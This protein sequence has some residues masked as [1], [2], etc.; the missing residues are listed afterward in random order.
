MNYSGSIRPV[1]AAI[2]VGVAG[3]S[4]A[5]ALQG[6]DQSFVHEQ[7]FSYYYNWEEGMPA[8]PGY[9]SVFYENI[10]TYGWY[11][12]TGDT[13]DNNPYGM[14]FDRDLYRVNRILT[15][16]PGQGGTFTPRSA[17]HYGRIAP[18][19][20]FNSNLGVGTFSDSGVRR[21]STLSPFRGSGNQITGL[22]LIHAASGSLVSTD[23]NRNLFSAFDVNYPDHLVLGVK[24]SNFRLRLDGA[25]QQ[26]YEAHALESFPVY[27]NLTLSFD[28]LMGLEP[29]IRYSF[30]PR[31]YLFDFNLLQI[32]Y[33]YILEDRFAFDLNLPPYNLTPDSK[34]YL[35]YAVFMGGFDGHTEDFAMDR[36]GYIGHYRTEEHFSQTYFEGEELLRLGSLFDLEFD[37]GIS[38]IRAPQPPVLGL[39]Y[40]VNSTTTGFGMWNGTVW[41]RTG[42]SFWTA[43][44]LGDEQ[45][46]EWD[47]SG[48]GVET[49]IFDLAGQPGVP[50]VF[51]AETIPMASSKLFIEGLG[52]E[53]DGKAVL[54]FY[55]QPV[56][57]ENGFIDIE[58]EEQA[59]RAD[60]WISGSFTLQGNGTLIAGNG[61]LLG[62]AV[63][64]ENG[65]LFLDHEESVDSQTSIAL[66]PDNLSHT[67]PTLTLNRSVSLHELSAGNFTVIRPSESSNATLTLTGN[68]TIR[69]DLT[70]AWDTATNLPRVMSVTIDAPDSTVTFYSPGKVHTG[71]TTLVAGTLNTVGTDALSSDS[72]MVVHGGLLYINGLQ[73][74]LGLS[75]TG[76]EIRGLEDS[77]RGL[78]IAL[79]KIIRP[80]YSNSDRV[81]I[82]SGTF[83][84]DLHVEVWYVDFRVGGNN[85]HTGW[86]STPNSTDSFSV[87][88]DSKLTLGLGGDSGD[89]GFGM[90]H[91]FSGDLVVDR[92][93][94]YLMPNIIYGSGNLTKDGTG[95]LILTGENTYSGT[96]VV[97]SGRLF[98]NSAS[99][100]GGS[101]LVKSGATVGGNGSKSGEMILES[102]AR[103]APGASVGELSTGNQT[104]NG[105]SI[106]EFE[107]TTDGSSGSAGASWDK[108]TVNG[109]LDMT[110]ASNISPVVIEL[111]TMRDIISRGVLNSWNPTA[112]AKWTDFVTTTDGILGYDVDKFSFD[113]DAFA[114]PLAPNG[115]FWVSL[116]GG[117]NNLDLNYSLPGLIFD[118]N[119]MS[120]GYGNWAS[121]IP[122]MWDV[123]TTR[124]F[125]RSATGSN[126]TNTWQYGGGGVETTIFDVTGQTGAAR[127]QVVG[128]IEMGASTLLVNGTSTQ[129]LTLQGGLLNFSNGTI[130]VREPSQ[131]LRIAGNASIS[132][133]ATKSGPGKLEVA[134]NLLNS[135]LSVDDG[136]LRLMTS[137]NTGNNTRL[138]L[139]S[140]NAKLELAGNGTFRLGA[141]NTTSGSLARAI[142]G[143]V[144]ELQLVLMNGETNFLY[145]RLFD[146]SA[147]LSLT[148]TGAGAALL[149]T[150][151]AATYSGQTLVNGAT[152]V[153]AAY[154]S[155]SPNSVHNL[156]S[157]GLLSITAD[158]V[159]AGLMGNGRVA[160]NGQLTIR[161]LLDLEFSGTIED[162]DSGVMSLMK[163]YSGLL[164]LS[165]NNTFTGTTLIEAGELRIGAGGTTGTLLGNGLVSNNA[166][167]SFNRSDE[168]LFGSLISGSGRIVQLGNGTTTLTGNNTFQ[169]PSIIRN[170]TLQLGNGGISGAIGLGPVENEAILSFNRSD[171]VILPNSIGGNGSVEQRGTGT[172]TL[173]FNNTYSGG[174]WIRNGALRIG[175]NGTTGWFGSGQVRDDSLLVFNR[176]DNITVE[177][178]IYG[179]GNLTQI[180]PGRLTLTANNTYS[181]FTRL[182]NG[183]FALSAGS[184]HTG[185]STYF[186]DNG[187]RFLPSEHSL[188]TNSAG[189]G[190]AL[191][192]LSG[193]IFSFS[194]NWNTSGRSVKV[195]NLG[196]LSPG[197]FIE[198]TRWQNVEEP[199]FNLGGGRFDVSEAQRRVRT[200][201]LGRFVA[202]GDLKFD[203]YDELGGEKPVQGIGERGDRVTLI[204]G[205]FDIGP[206]LS[207]AQ[208]NFNFARPVAEL[209]AG[210]YII[211]DGDMPV[212]GALALNSANHPTYYVHDTYLV[213]LSLEDANPAGGFNDVAVNLVRPV[214]YQLI[215]ED[216]QDHPQT[217]LADTQ[218]Q[219]TF[220]PNSP[221]KVSDRAFESVYFG[222]INS[223]A[224]VSAYGV[225][226]DAEGGGSLWYGRATGTADYPL[227]LLSRQNATDSNVLPDSPGTDLVP[228]QTLDI[229]N[230]DGSVRIATSEI[231]NYRASGYS[232]HP[233]GYLTMITDPKDGAFF[234]GMPMTTEAGNVIGLYKRTWLNVASGAGW[235]AS[236]GDP[237]LSEYSY[238]GVSTPLLVNDAG[239][240]LQLG[241]LTSGNHTQ[242]AW[243][244][245]GEMVGREASF[246]R[247]AP[248]GQRVGDFSAG[249]NYAPGLALSDDG[250]LTFRASGVFEGPG[251]SANFTS[252]VNRQ[253]LFRASGPDGA[254]V[255][256]VELVLRG[257]A[258]GLTDSVA[259]TNRFSYTANYVNGTE[260]ATTQLSVSEIAQTVSVNADGQTATVVRSFVSPDDLGNLSTVDAVVFINGTHGTN[261]NDPGD[262]YTTVI[263]RDGDAVYRG[264]VFAGVTQDIRFGMDQVAATTNGSVGRVYY[265]AGISSGGSSIFYWDEGDRVANALFLPGETLSVSLRHPELPRINLTLG[266][267][268]LNNSRNLGAWQVNARGDVAAETWGSWVPENNVTAQAR[269]FHGVL[270]WDWNGSNYNLS[271]IV[272]EGDTVDN[273]DGTYATLDWM[274]LPGDWVVSNGLDGRPTWFNDNGKITFYGQLHYF[275][276]DPSGAEGY[277]IV[278]EEGVFAPFDLP[279]FGRPIPEPKAITLL[280]LSILA[281]LFH[282]KNHKWLLSHKR[283]F[284]Q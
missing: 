148:T 210:K 221:S 67:W 79:L 85:T 100:G 75:G 167:L 56:N 1:N 277:T 60:N 216:D 184:S 132:G 110:A 71:N 162:A 43:S 39:R 8:T 86:S 40:D 6:Y 160:G 187:S 171:N 244:V 30:D 55:G 15:W 231:Q 93:N 198:G 237:L 235:G 44:N 181:G 89:A 38:L 229:L 224:F 20:S 36:G 259:Q 137:G 2:A 203:L 133:S 47:T 124:N 99:T 182:M 49:T 41:D 173:T 179:T 251:A 172:T 19:I 146:G 190:D 246:V 140:A 25:W 144:A 4:L 115:F 159:I 90:I 238:T 266:N 46:H 59:M 284:R 103:I 22:N 14:L 225:L 204:N 142:D 83:T 82:Y 9:Y 48:G 196:I 261:I 212:S 253:S 101:T 232:T 274:R 108:L 255:E 256:N 185:G 166:T 197:A 149:G 116:S 281:L 262:G 156:T 279:G 234:V 264:G 233:S 257:A 72:H 33:N 131:T 26:M 24:L 16:N 98:F 105:G 69:G 70:D 128:P 158:Q 157:P 27:V 7:T 168:L 87:F 58:R 217:R 29:Q 109:S 177:N 202:D 134:G 151:G 96:T 113:L 201:V 136:L 81:N 169:G 161:Q 3:L 241:A 260:G 240:T 118:S 227:R 208:F 135:Q 62:T 258:F 175:N 52:E 211:M 268:P 153:A 215:Y 272:M 282:S 111:V 121:E 18:R 186:V 73:T 209:Q 165:G 226:S 10:Y 126:P 199:T 178:L 236:N 92:S 106:F 35:D 252:S 218:G 28:N 194:G 219:T 222:S 275:M 77:R 123:N 273:T 68:A 213:H 223:A 63:T 180:G 74:V 31:N 150:T 145:G 206:A 13:P 57:F 88:W 130:T 248:A 94:T 174:T 276:R 45:T 50:S 193:G 245:A 64:V 265:S 127:V 195:Y 114:N 214:G 269:D 54:R 270:F 271:R 139:T 191:K 188:I 192:V 117:N 283:S 220:L 155:L 267:D 76:G 17:E 125:T 230:P 119:G 53:I 97:N 152:L 34:L 164:T 84:G 51:V 163:D 12:T 61:T 5:G 107:F 200:D 112:D 189:V 280:I 65:V 32:N 147:I 129:P 239:Q 228:F 66:L 243:V 170:G 138:A 205:G 102:G 122:P 254:A 141:L 207:V 183:E 247:G 242:N 154:N 263:A 120:A 143:M 95:D 42:H 104:W 37:L 91:L 176:S 80:D 11:P 278:Y 21:Y 23:F 249:S 78:D 250:G